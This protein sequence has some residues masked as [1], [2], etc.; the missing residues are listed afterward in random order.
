MPN[1]LYCTYITFTHSRGANQPSFNIVHALNTKKETQRRMIEGVQ[2]TISASLTSLGIPTS[3]LMVGLYCS[4]TV[5]P[6]CTHI[7]TTAGA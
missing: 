5:A 2:T 4:G 3:I 1:F 6:P 7:S